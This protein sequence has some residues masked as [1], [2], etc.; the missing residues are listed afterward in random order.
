M[1]APPSIRVCTLNILAP[2]L[3]CY[4]WRSSYGLPL[5]SSDDAYDAVTALRMKNITDL[6][7]ALNPTILCLQEV[8]DTR[9]QTL[10]WHPVAE[11]IAAKC[12]FKIAGRS[13][14]GSEMSWD[15]PAREQ[16]RGSPKR[17][18]SGVAT[19]YKPE[20]VRHLGQVSKAETHGPSALFNTGYG[21]PF[22]LDKFEVL[23]GGGGGGGGRKGTSTPLTF[24][25][26]NIHVRM[27]FP[28][29]LKPMT[30]LLQRIR[31]SLPT[32]V[33]ATASPWER[34]ILAG[35][36]N[37]G[38][39]E[40]N[41]DWKN[42]L[43]VQTQLTDVPLDGEVGGGG[44]GGGGVVD[45]P[46]PGMITSYWAPHFKLKARWHMLPHPHCWTLTRSL[47]GCLPPPLNTGE[48]R[49]HPTP[50]TRA[51]RS[52]WGD[53]VPVTTLLFT[54]TW[55]SLPYLVK[56]APRKGYTLG[57]QKLLSYASYF[58]CF[59]LLPRKAFNLSI[60]TLTLSISACHAKHMRKHPG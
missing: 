12:G 29:I 35:D 20:V 31:A 41:L 44:G 36:F 30:E 43:S 47:Q 60:P 5:L 58:Y 24:H 45:F 8:T 48:L 4:F 50:F 28:N 26:A 21:S 42:I 10:E 23:G 7:C 39:R 15:Y 33:P 6:V 27:T 32:P 56:R 18:D 53:S 49:A 25:V 54:A 51:T 16:N 14:K 38:S 11:F 17:V 46:R 9:V 37:S 57:L 22:S 55:F 19:L 2:E 34:L 1:S 3:M 59:T 13:Y 40:A 52:C